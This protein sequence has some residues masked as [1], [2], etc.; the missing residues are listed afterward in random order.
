MLV[1][2]DENLGARGAAIL[3]GAGWDVSTVAMQDL[4][5][6]S[7]ATLIEICRVEG[8]VL[9]TLDLDFANTL[10][11]PPRRYGGIVV[12]RLQAPVRRA[13][14]EGALQRLV[15]L[16]ATRSPAGRLWIID[17]TRIREFEGRDPD[18]GG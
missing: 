11:L 6:A 3:R 17:E 10:R 4:C 13:A 5:G 14:I 1:K 9:I 7:D 18:D 15:L 2:L 16:A 12:L 8:R